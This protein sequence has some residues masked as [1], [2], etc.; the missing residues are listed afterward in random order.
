MILLAARAA[1]RDLVEA[2]LVGHVA[3]SCEQRDRHIAA[4]PEAPVSTLIA[5]TFS[6]N[7]NAR[8]SSHTHVF[9]HTHT[10]SQHAPI[11]RRA[12]DLAACSRAP[13]RLPCHTRCAQASVSAHRCI[14]WSRREA[15][16][17]LTAL[18]IPAPPRPRSAHSPAIASLALG[19]NGRACVRACASACASACVRVCV[20]ARVRVCVCALLAPGVIAGPVGGWRRPLPHSRW[21]QGAHA[22]SASQER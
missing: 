14:A 21:R 11:L 5:L 15:L 12:P 16:A 20:R 2:T 3:L 6:H 9:T 18:W 7:H 1:G 17:S 22:G 19:T 13:T 10:H 8:R 4:D